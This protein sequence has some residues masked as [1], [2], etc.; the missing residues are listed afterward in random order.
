MRIRLPIRVFVTEWAIDN[1]HLAEEYWAAVDL[2]EK[3]VHI[4]EPCNLKM[5]ETGVIEGFSVSVELATEFSKRRIWELTTVDNFF[6]KN[7]EYEFQENNRNRL[8]ISLAY[9]FAIYTMN[10][11]LARDI[12]AVMSFQNEPETFGRLENY[13]AE[14]YKKEMIRLN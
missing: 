8:I 7:C 6:E 2:Y 10:S 11:E 4:K 3:N 12:N 9:I 13:F 5:S 1:N 14:R